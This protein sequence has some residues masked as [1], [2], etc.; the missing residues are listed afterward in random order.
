MFCHSNDWIYDYPKMY[1][2]KLYFNDYLVIII[3]IS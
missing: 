3:N 2:K 1:E